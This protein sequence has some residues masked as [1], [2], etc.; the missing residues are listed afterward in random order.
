MKTEECFIGMLSVSC[1][2]IADEYIK[3]KTLLDT[4]KL[5]NYNKILLRQLGLNSMVDIFEE[6]NIINKDLFIS[7]KD[8]FGNYILNNNYY[9]YLYQ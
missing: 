6:S 1:T 8:K 5:S 7:S 2:E 4:M 9:P 3:T